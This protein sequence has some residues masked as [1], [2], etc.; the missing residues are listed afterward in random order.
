MFGQFLLIA[1]KHRRQINE[2]FVKWS[3][4]IQSLGAFMILQFRLH[5]DTLQFC[6]VDSQ[7]ESDN[8][9][10]NNSLL[11]SLKTNEFVMC[12]VDRCRFGNEKTHQLAL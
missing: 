12:P 2:V 9:L 10:M 6:S 7:R 3:D 4:I 11:V 8:K 1:G 5:N